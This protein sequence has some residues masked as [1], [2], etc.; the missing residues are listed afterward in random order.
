MLSGDAYIQ[1]NKKSMD[2]E[3]NMDYL[4]QNSKENA[5]IRKTFC[6]QACKFS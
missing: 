1:M 3:M 5:Y 6:I 4:S 2:N